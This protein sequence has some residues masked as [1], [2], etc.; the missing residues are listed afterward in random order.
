MDRLGIVLWL[1]LIVVAAAIARK[2]GRELFPWIVYSGYLAPVALIHALVIPKGPRGPEERG[3]FLSFVT[4]AMGAFLVAALYL[5]LLMI[6]Y[7]VNKGPAVFGEPLHVWVRGAAVVTAGVL[8]ALLRWRSNRAE[9][10]GFIAM[11]GMFTIGMIA[12][13][14][15]QSSAR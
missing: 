13:L 15:M 14:F 12:W 10:I 9:A 3:A 8:G 2:K 1:A 5:W 4:G 6:V 11:A 7:G